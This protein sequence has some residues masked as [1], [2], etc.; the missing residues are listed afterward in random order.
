MG[1]T[2]HLVKVHKEATRNYNTLSKDSL[3]LLISCSVE[4]PSGFN[5]VIAGDMNFHST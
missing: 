3:Y 5:V 1:Q 2:L 4:D